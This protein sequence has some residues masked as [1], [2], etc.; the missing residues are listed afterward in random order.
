MLWGGALDIR[1]MLHSGSENAAKLPNVLLIEYLIYYTTRGGVVRCLRRDVRVQRR[2]GRV[3]RR[4][5]RI[6]CSIR[7]HTSAYVGVH[8]SA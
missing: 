3:H 7:Q 6:A 1:G 4:L 2:R 8:T 5:M